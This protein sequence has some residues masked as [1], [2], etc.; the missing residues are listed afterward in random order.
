MANFKRNSRLRQIAS[1]KDR[2][3]LSDES[4]ATMFDGLVPRNA[5]QSVSFN[6]LLSELAVHF[7][8]GF[9]LASLAARKKKPIWIVSW[10][11]LLGL[12]KM[13]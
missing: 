9:E 8:W 11:I 10:F 5:K 12:I 13:F 3:C 1:T 6:T 7:E 4:D 2:K